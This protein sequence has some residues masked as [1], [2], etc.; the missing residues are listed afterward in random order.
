MEL[1][2]V[3]AISSVVCFILEM[4]ISG[5]LIACFGV[6]A[7]VSAGIALLRFPLEIQLL[8][9]WI[10][11]LLV[12][13]RLRPLFLRTLKRSKTRM[14]A[15]ALIGKTGRVIERIIPSQGKG[16]VVVDGEDWWTDTLFGEDI[17]EGEIV[18]VTQ[19]VGAKLIVTREG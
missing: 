11:S 10:V 1:W 17:E 3:W 2:L 8:A 18:I 9:F 14:N 15:E 19:V 6:A 16:R 7:M 13:F 5:F 4:L 12:L